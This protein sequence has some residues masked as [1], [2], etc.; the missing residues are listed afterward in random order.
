[1]FI[2]ELKTKEKSRT[3]CPAFLLFDI[4]PLGF[5]AIFQFPSK[6]RQAP[7]IAHRSFVD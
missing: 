2:F 1:M 3:K 5:A 7:V 6:T 4:V